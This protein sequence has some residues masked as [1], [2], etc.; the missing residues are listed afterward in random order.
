MVSVFGVIF[1]FYPLHYE[2]RSLSQYL[3]VGKKVQ[4]FKIT[5][6]F[7]LIHPCVLY[8]TVTQHLFSGA[9]TS[10]KNSTIVLYKKLPILTPN[11]IVCSYLRSASRTNQ[12]IWLQLA[13]C[14]L[15]CGFYVPSPQYRSRLIVMFSRI[16]T[17]STGAAK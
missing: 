4:N 12:T 16:C 14:L 10:L 13:P 8:E 17:I 6:Y 15:L 5:K 11:S 3:L 1:S 7:L 2:T 9:S